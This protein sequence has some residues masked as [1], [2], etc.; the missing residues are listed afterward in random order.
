MLILIINNFIMSSKYELDNNQ[1]CCF[2]I[3]YNNESKIDESK[4]DESKIDE[5]KIDESKIDEHKIDEHKI[6]E[7]KIDEHKIDEH[8]I[9]DTNLYKN[10]LLNKQKIIMNNYTE[11]KLINKDLILN[12]IYSNDD[13]IYLQ[14]YN[15]I[16]NPYQKRLNI[17]SLLLKSDLV[18]PM[19]N[20]L[21]IIK[22]FNWLSPFNN[23]Y[24]LS[25]KD[26]AIKKIKYG[27]KKKIL[28]QNSISK[29]DINNSFYYNYIDLIKKKLILSSIKYYYL[30][31]KSKRFNKVKDIIWVF[32]D[33]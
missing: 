30:E 18:I 25:S 1:S 6:D 23:E 15:K 24:K 10:V 7:H 16:D 8:K 4:I 11:T 9:N 14:I 5:S 13:D 3:F 2:K 19:N 33:N 26:W 27:N 32:Y 21:D 20:C 31:F 22:F 28:L 17:I 12:N 29:K